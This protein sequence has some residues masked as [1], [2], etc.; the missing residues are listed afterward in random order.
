MAT[1]SKPSV[2]NKI[3]YII[4]NKYYLTRILGS[5]ASGTV[6]HAKN[7][8]TNEDFAI[9]LIVKPDAKEV[10]STASSFE[11]NEYRSM[12]AIPVSLSREDIQST[13]NHPVH[14]LPPLY[15]EVLLHS[16]VHSHPNILSVIEV[17]DASNFVC[18]VLDF[19]EMGDLFSAITERNWYVGDESLAKELFLQLLDAVEFC[20]SKS[21]F[22]CDLKPENILVGGA[23]TT[24]KIADFGLASQSPL[25][26]VF[27][28]GSSYYMAPET[29]AENVCYR[30]HIPE[31]R[32]EP[33]LRRRSET[34]AHI[35]RGERK[36]TP[37]QSKGYPRASSDVWALG[38]IF[39]NLIF[40]RNPWKKASLVEDA[41]YRDYSHNTSTLKGILPVSDELCMIM[42]QVFHPNP[43][44]RVSISHLRQL[45]INCRVLAHNNNDFSWYKCARPK[46]VAPPRRPP[47]PIRVIQ[48]SA[49]RTSDCKGIQKDTSR[50]LSDVT[51][52]HIENANTTSIGSRVSQPRIIHVL[53][54][55]GKKYMPTVISPPVTGTSAH[56][57]GCNEVSSASSS[58]SVSSTFSQRKRKIVEKFQFVKNPGH[59]Y[60]VTP[61]KS[62]MSSAA[63]SNTK[64]M[65]DP[66]SHSLY[67]C[68]ASSITSK[69]I[70]STS[71]L[72]H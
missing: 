58:S 22:H 20:H 40:G 70:R 45:V 54:C 44:K 65:F 16:S 5:G 4:N 37:L 64:V 26:S 7:I 12:Q 63:V 9:K 49:A 72:Q 50:Y 2:S 15:K 48:K 27:G 25:C 23:G 30:K 42:S 31:P 33:I 39:L 24:L 60:P 71:L 55:H 47:T 62:P 17:L 6:Y 35:S 29:I 13:P 69:R 67:L 28:R 38:I 46:A 53:S 19:C 61:E 10:D 56:S 52:V 32:K 8:Q 43:Y 51:Y 41:A 66:N 57:S 34:A 21:I 36:R 3:G 1:S 68:S 18:L 14:T 59:L 11:F